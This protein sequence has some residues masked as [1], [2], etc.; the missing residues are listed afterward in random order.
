MKIFCG[1]STKYIRI[2][3]NFKSISTHKCKNLPGVATIT[4]GHECIAENCAFIGSP[5]NTKM[6]FKFM[7]LPISLINLNVWTASSLVGDR[8]KARAFVVAC[9]D[10]NF[11]NKGIRKQAVL[12]EPIEWNNE[13]NEW[14]LYGENV[15]IEFYEYIP[16]LAIATTSLP[17][18]IN[19]IVFRWTGVGIL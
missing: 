5:P 3:D 7:N 10:C 14:A 17:S 15:E 18:R 19:G 16:V 2:D 12:P 1:L 6:V 9:L 11:S 8:I 4:S 13:L